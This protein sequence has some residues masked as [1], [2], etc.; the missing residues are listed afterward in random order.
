[1]LGAGILIFVC[2]LAV[3]AT[4]RVARRRCPE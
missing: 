3:I 1:V 2:V 4:R